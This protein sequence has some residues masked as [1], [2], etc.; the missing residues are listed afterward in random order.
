[1]IAQYAPF[2]VLAI[3]LTATVLELRTG[4]ISNWIPLLLF[5]LFIAIAATIPDRSALAG[6]LLVAL[7]VFGIGLI[8][9]AVNFFGAGAV[10]LMSGAALFTPLD[11]GWITAGIFVV[12]LVIVTLGVVRA[13]RKYGSDDSKWAVLA[14]ET[15]PMSMTLS[16][17]AA[18]VFFVV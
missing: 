15:L 11:K 7:A 14:K 1:M 5:A 10:K 16:I 13:R 4:K 2:A 6:Q 8:L 3:L 12:T 18:L 17:T 9:F